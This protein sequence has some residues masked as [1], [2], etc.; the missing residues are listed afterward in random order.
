[1]HLVGFYLWIVLWCRDPRTSGLGL[2]LSSLTR[3]GKSLLWN[4]HWSIGQDPWMWPPSISRPDL[5]NIL[6]SSPVLSTGLWSLPLR[7]SD[8][9]F[10]ELIVFLCVLNSHTPQFLF[11]RYCYY[12]QTKLWEASLCIPFKFRF[13]HLI[14]QHLEPRYSHPVLHLIHSIYSDPEVYIVIV[15]VY[16][17][18]LLQFQLV[19]CLWQFLYA[20]WNLSY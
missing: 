12:M 4:A 14:S 16:S 8:R 3:H 1:M 11:N 2:Y 13:F 7:F 18:I 9:T 20:V 10:Y 15:T 19:L 5:I 6:G 17:L